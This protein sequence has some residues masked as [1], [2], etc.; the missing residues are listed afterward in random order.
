VQVPVT[1]AQPMMMG[2]GLGQVQPQPQPRPSPVAP[3][4][5]VLPI[6]QLMLRRDEVGS[7]R[8]AR[9]NAELLVVLI[10]A[11]TGAD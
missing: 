5:G 6:D 8:N 4:A 3:V 9:I 11:V 7:N 10:A 2:P 1:M